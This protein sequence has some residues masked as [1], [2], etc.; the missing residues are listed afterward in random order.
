[1]VQQDGPALFTPPSTIWIGGRLLPRSWTRE[2]GAGVVSL[3]RVTTVTFCVS[4]EG[5][6]C[7]S[8]PSA[9]ARV[10]QTQRAASAG[11]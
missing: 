4:L 8:A 10:E 6:P 5:A 7:P 9:Y 11:R 1:M 3:Y 2:P